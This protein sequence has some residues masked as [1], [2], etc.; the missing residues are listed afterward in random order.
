MSKNTFFLKAEKRTDIGKGA[1]RR[2][3]REDK[4]PAVIYGGEGEAKSIT[5]SHFAILKLLND[6]SVYSQ[7]ID[8]EVDGEVT[9]TILR[10]L[11]RHPYK[12]SIL[13]VDFQ[14]VV[15]GQ[16]ITVNVPIH[17]LNMDT[18]AG[19]KAGGIVNQHII[20]IE[21]SARP[22]ALPESLEVDVADMQIGDNMHLS[23][24]KVPEGVTIIALENSDDADIPIISI[25][26]PKAKV[27][28]E[29]EEAATE[30]ESAESESES[31]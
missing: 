6:D 5:I 15:R 12:P 24:I 4:V 1:S 2:L 14:R 16:V 10:D 31:E 23:E 9:E 19:A 27:E 17:Y 26:A 18:C 13:H 22:S 11:Q 21:V 20:D 30:T 8:V 28:E 7:L 29:T 25:H 3:R